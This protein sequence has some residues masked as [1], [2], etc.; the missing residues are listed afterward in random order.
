MPEKFSGDAKALSYFL[1][2]ISLYADVIGISNAMEKIKLAVILLS[3]QA[4]TWWRS[5][6]MEAWATLGYCD[7]VMFASKL[8]D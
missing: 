4:L 3:G 2:T 1:F 7:W 6:S 5:V 8:S